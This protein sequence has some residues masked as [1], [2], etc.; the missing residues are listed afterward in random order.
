MK[1]QSS[2]QVVL[3]THA[4]MLAPSL[5]PSKQACLCIRLLTV[6]PLS[7]L[8]DHAKQEAL[9]LSHSG[10]QDRAVPDVG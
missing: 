5:V 4:R 9:W 7:A 2:G 3:V 8:S 6:G 1:L 10:P